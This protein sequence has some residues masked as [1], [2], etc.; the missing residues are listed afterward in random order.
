MRPLKG[1]RQCWAHSASVTTERAEA[2]RQGGR[3]RTARV[4]TVPVTT[5]ADLQ[6]VIGAELGAVRRLTSTTQR[7]NSVARLVVAALTLIE[8]GDLEERI[9]AL[10]RR[11]RWKES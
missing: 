9:A 6:Q 5:I 8:K 11:A 2:R 10:E 4:Q 3:N 1:R 7:A